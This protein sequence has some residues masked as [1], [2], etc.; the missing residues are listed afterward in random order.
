MITVSGRR[1][2]A[3]S[4]ALAAAMNQSDKLVEDKI[5]VYYYEMER[6]RKTSSCASM[7]MRWERRC[8]AIISQICFFAS[9][10]SHSLNLFYYSTK[11]IRIDYILVILHRNGTH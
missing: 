11:M 10:S 7:G 8:F 2:V 9:D 6:K 5:W 4:S 1:G 3:I